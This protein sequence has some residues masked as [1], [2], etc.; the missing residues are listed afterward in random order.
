MFEY[1]G[2]ILVLLSWLGGIILVRKLHIT[3]AMSLSLHAASNKATSRLFTLSLVALGLTFFWWFTR[4]FA[5]H[6]GLPIVFTVLLA[7][8]LACQCIA[9]LVPDT[10]GWRHTVHYIVAYTMAYLYL[11]LGLLILSAHRVS[12]TAKIL[13][14][15]CF[16][17]M[18]AA[19]LLFWFV[20]RVR[21][22]YLIFQT[23]YVVAFQLIVLVAAYL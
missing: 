5:P 14:T 18:I 2:L 9:G 10:G 12:L 4:W 8:T 21:P 16:A 13:G 6:L 23:S 1:F 3:N 19:L 7:M 20:K 11:P 15:M 17:Y 22:H